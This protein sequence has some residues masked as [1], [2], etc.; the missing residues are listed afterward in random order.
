MECTRES[1]GE[2]TTPASADTGRAPAR[3]RRVK[4]AL[5]VGKAASGSPTSDMSTS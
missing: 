1:H 2:T 4:K 5:N 3:S